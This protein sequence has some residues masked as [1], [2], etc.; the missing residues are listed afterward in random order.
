MTA[1]NAPEVTWSAD[2]PISVARLQQFSDSLYYLLNTRPVY[3]GID[4][5]SYSTTSTSYV[6][7][8]G[9]FTATITPNSGRLLLQMGFFLTV[10]NVAGNGWLTILLDGVDQYP[11][12][13]LY[14]FQQNG[15]CY[16]S[17][18]QWFSGLSVAAH[19][20]KLQ[21]KVS[22]GTQQIS[23]GSP[24]PNVLAFANSFLVR[25]V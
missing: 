1:W 21:Y 12:N 24:S 3:S 15:G 20:L 2:K 22:V 6:D 25:E 11:T 23:I 5:G 10:Q 16:V 14:K 4:Q 18:S 8:G 17:F 13:G 7:V 9:I 19:T